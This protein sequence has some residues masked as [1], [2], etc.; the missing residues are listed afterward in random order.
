[1]DED[2][3]EAGKMAERLSEEVLNEGHGASLPSALS[4]AWLQ[5]AKESCEK[6]FAE[7]PDCPDESDHEVVASTMLMMLVMKA[8]HDQGTVD[9]S[10]EGVP[11]GKMQEYISMYRLEV[12]LESFRRRGL[13]QSTPATLEDIFDRKRKIRYSGKIIDDMCRERAGDSLN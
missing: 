4:D 2:M 9:V 10:R 6:V 13:V 1:M 12:H 7:L 11:L 3:R 5:R 8:L